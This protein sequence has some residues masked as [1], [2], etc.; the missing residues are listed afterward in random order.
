MK[1]FNGK[2]SNKIIACAGL[3]LLIAV[4]FGGCTKAENTVEYSLGSMSFNVFERWILDETNSDEEHLSFVRNDGS[5]ENTV[6]DSMMVKTGKVTF[7]DK[8][9]TGNGTIKTKEDIVKRFSYGSSDYVDLTFSEWKTTNEIEYCEQFFEVDGK[10]ADGSTGKR[11]GREIVIP[12]N[13]TE[14]YFIAMA[15]GDD[16]ADLKDLDVIIHS[17]SETTSPKFA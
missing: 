6:K 5:I 1:N 9:D 14:A 15:V 11:Y 8:I 3:V 4:I 7:L 17:L 10:L 12:I 16:K 13:E 2:T